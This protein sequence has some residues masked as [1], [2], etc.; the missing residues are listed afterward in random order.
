MVTT[1][2]YRC[3]HPIWQVHQLARWWP[4]LE[5]PADLACFCLQ[6][7]ATKLHSADSLEI[8]HFE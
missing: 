7:L 6:V 1:G 4:F 2:F 8:I 5:F 3:H